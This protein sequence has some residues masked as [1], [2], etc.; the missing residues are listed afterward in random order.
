MNHGLIRLCLLGH[1]EPELGHQSI[2]KHML[3]PTICQA[4]GGCLD[5]GNSREF[6]TGNISLKYLKT[7]G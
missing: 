4:F 2:I 1:T 6:N 3:S 5:G 7:K